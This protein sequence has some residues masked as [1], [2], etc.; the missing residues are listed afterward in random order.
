MLGEF[1]AKIKQGLAKTRSEGAIAIAEDGGGVEADRDDRE[2]QRDAVGLVNLRAEE[3][4]A[5]HST[6]LNAMLTE[7]ADLT[8]AIAR[9]R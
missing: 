2:R 9:L 3:E 4:A 1:L 5:E 6:R 8:G 7:R